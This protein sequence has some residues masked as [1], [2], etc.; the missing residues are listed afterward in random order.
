[1]DWSAGWLDELQGETHLLIPPNS[2]HSLATGLPEVL[3]TMSAS[4]LS[5]ARNEPS[6]SRPHFNYSVDKAT[7]ELVMSQD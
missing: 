2:E 6:T 3:E 5:I 1:M 7:G 4:F